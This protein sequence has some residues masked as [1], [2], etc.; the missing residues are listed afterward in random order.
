ML[1][2]DVWHKSKN[3]KAEF[4]RTFKS[5]ELSDEAQQHGITGQ[6]IV[7]HFRHS[8]DVCSGDPDKL[9]SNFRSLRKHYFDE[10]SHMSEEFR[11]KLDAYVDKVLPKK[12]VVSYVKGFCTDWEEA[13]HSQSLRYWQKGVPYSFHNWLAR[14]SLHVLDWGE[15]FRQKSRTVR[16]RKEIVRQFDEFMQTRNSYS[17][18]KPKIDLTKYFVSAGKRPNTSSSTKLQQCEKRQKT[19]LA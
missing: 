12:E 2:I 6:K 17:S 5:T 8:I 15:N 11:K 1:H 18:V 14:Q 13:F 9:Y 7:N 19:A 16:F 3:M 10:A 4:R